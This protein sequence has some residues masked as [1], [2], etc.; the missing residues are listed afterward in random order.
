MTKKA[1]SGKKKGKKI[2]VFGEDEN[3]TKT[4]AELLGA[5][6]PEA[7]GI[8]LPFRRPPILFKDA[9]TRD[10]PSRVEVIA[11][12]IE[13]ERTQ[14]DVICVFAHEDCDDFE[15]AHDALG[16]KI[17]SAFAEAGYQ[18][19]AV[20]PAWETEAWLFLWPEAVAAHRAGW[21]SLD[22][23]RGRDVGRIKDAKEE[24]RRA[25]RPIGKG[26]G[27]PR[28]YRESDAPAIAAKVREMGL[29]DSPGGRSASYSRFVET[30]ATCCETLRS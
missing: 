19:H 21:R 6:C 22:R 28:E 18:V 24:L 4:I 9:A 14:W 26:A 12:L 10:L 11:S 23:F 2:L 27:N 8:I 7:I 5:L 20:T 29:A 30:V 3:D 25:L 17:E 15:P 16:Q 13:A 1:K